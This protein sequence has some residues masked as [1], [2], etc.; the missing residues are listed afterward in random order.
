[1]TDGVTDTSLE[2]YLLGDLTD[3]QSGET[4]TGE[5]SPAG[6]ASSTGAPSNTSNGP[7]EAEGYTIT[8]GHTA[9]DVDEDSTNE[10]YAVTIN[11]NSVPLTRIYQKLQYDSWR[12]ETTQILPDRPG[13]DEEG[14]FYR[15][16]GDI[17]A[18]LDAETG[19]GVSE[20]DVVTG[21][22]SSATGVVVATDYTGTIKY[23]VLHDVV[24]T[25]EDNDVI[26]ASGQQGVNDNTIAGTPQAIS[27]NAAA[28]FGT[29][30][31]GKFFGARGVYLSG[32][33]AAD[34]NNYQLIDVTGTTYSP[35]AQRT[36]TFSGLEANARAFVAE[37]ATAGGTD[38][39]KTQNGVGAAGAAISDVVIPLDSTPPSDVPASGWLRVEDGST[40][41]QYRYEYASWDSTPQA[42][43]VT[44]ANLSGTTTSTGSST[45]LNDTG[46][47]ASYGSD[48]NVKTGHL[49]R[50]TSSGGWARV[51]R[52]ISDDQIE[53]TVLSTGTWTDATAW[54]ANQVV[55]AL[56]DA[57]TL[58]FPYIDEEVS[59][60]SIAVNIKYDDVAEIVCRARFSDVDVGPSDR[61]L[62]FEQLGL[63]VTD[64]DL[65]IIATLNDDDIAAT[66]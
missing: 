21:S 50:N 59:G 32:V 57:D 36:I 31:G 16:V 42:T 29:F 13:D 11:C 35:P 60:T 28:P 38:I 2:Y 19:A 61:K 51:L 6:S 7:A 41:E 46:A 4:I 54:E 15:A 62:P 23:V 33:A 27:D 26:Y 56:V 37:V 5:N 20:G 22:L 17:Y 24:G 3:F 30:A 9:Q 14:Q 52:K 63:Q 44:H 64:A 40:N 49:I 8:F 45:L 39:I 34:A 43:L 55:V 58:W 25:F 10:A 1:V 18:V 66:S 48:N 47:F 12:G 65:S 53:T